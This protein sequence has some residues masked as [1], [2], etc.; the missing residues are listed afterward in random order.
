MENLE[1][2]VDVYALVEINEYEISTLHAM[3]A[4]RLQNL[5]FRW[6][7]ACHLDMDI[8]LAR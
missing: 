6:Y 1:S 7:S 8:F 2:K 5:L 3:L 4:S